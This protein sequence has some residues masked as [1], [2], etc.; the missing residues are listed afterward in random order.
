MEEGLWKLSLIHPGLTGQAFVE[1]VEHGQIHPDPEPGLA[2]GQYRLEGWL[3][4]LAG[5]AMG[6]RWQ[7]RWEGQR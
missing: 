2:M 7:F 5:A 6:D 1:E 4:V 3:K